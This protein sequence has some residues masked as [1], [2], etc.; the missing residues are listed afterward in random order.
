MNA[1]K[2]TAEE[3]KEIFNARIA[4][5]TNADKIADLEIIREYFTNEKF[6]ATLEEMTFAANS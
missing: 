5:E 6:R 4:T 3:V 2:L 1:N